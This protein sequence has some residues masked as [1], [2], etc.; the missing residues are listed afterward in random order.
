[1]ATEDSKKS[2]ACH[3]TRSPGIV[4]QWTHSRHFEFDVDCIACHQA[5]SWAPDAF[6]HHGEL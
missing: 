5:E 1:M 6:E 2:V 3:S 4:Q